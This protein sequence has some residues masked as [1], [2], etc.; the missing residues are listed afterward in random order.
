MPQSTTTE[1]IIQ[2]RQPVLPFFFAGGGCGGGGAECHARPS[3]YNCCVELFGSGYQPGGSGAVAMQFPLLNLFGNLDDI[4][5]QFPWVRSTARLPRSDKRELS[6]DCALHID[7]I[8]AEVTVTKRG[9]ALSHS[10]VAQS[11]AANAADQKPTNPSTNET[12]RTVPRGQE[13]VGMLQ[14]GK[15]AV[16]ADPGGHPWGRGPAGG[17]RCC[18]RRVRRGRVRSVLGR[19]LRASWRRPRA[20]CGGRSCRGRRV[21][22]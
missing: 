22:R 19:S 4:P 3:Q 7:K 11:P 10:R 12:Q 13:K 18:V 21:P 14:P 8:K 17:S 2:I 6:K 15:S 20:R 16:R 5:P 1:P 9:I